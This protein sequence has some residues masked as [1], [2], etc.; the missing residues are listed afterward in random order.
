VSGLPFL[1]PGSG[2]EWLTWF[3][4]DASGLIAIVVGLVI[5]WLLVRILITRGVRRLMLR[6]EAAR[7]D[8]PAQVGR[9]TDTV[10]AAV[11]WGVTTLIVFIG[12]ALILDNVGLDITALV[13]SAGVAGLGLTFG[14]QQLVR[15]L[16][17]G[18]FILGENQFQVG[19]SV[20]V[21]GVTGVVLDVNPRRTL[22]RDADGHVVTVPNGQIDVATNMTRDFARVNLD[23]TVGY[24]EDIQRVTAVLNNVCAEAAAARPV[25]YVSA[26]RVLR[27]DR[28]A[29]SG[30]VLKVVGDVKPF[31][32]WDVT[33]DLRARIVERFRAEE[34]RMPPAP[35]A[36][37]PPAPD[38]ETAVSSAS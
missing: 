9:R 12:F 7:Y 28:F 5:F 32:Q 3:E 13:T 19:D 2:D 1:F 16:I 14:A 10:I 8:D 22:I 6:A 38:S 17:N 24:D 21:A 11:N 30:V 25:D 36:A 34:I 35:L 18:S 37:R 31:A 23:V 33:G 26:P 27:V 15:D 4:D 20:R 29:D